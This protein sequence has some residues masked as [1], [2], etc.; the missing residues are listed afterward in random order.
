MYLKSA[1]LNRLS[2]D[3]DEDRLN[4]RDT[5][6]K[7]H[8]HQDRESIDELAKDIEKLLDNAS[9]SLP[10]KVRDMELQFHLTRAF[11]DKIAFQLKLLH[12]QDYLQTI[13]KAREL[14]I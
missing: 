7:R 10:T 12:K 14:L 3:T 2:P 6:S 1:L 5:L 9:P 13:S 4:D 8:L 11:P